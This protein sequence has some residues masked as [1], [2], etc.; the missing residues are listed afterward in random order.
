MQSGSE[1][2][3]EAS[4]LQRA[5]ETKFFEQ[6][7]ITCSPKCFKGYWTAK[8]CILC[9]KIGEYEYGKLITQSIKRVK[10]H[11]IRLHF[12][13]MLLKIESFCI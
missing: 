3:F 9:T 12:I 8:K 7:V 1:L 11:A 13:L 2:T 10:I 5:K 6:I 4:A